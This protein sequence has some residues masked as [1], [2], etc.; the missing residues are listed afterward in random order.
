M[1]TL[2]VKDRVHD[3]KPILALRPAEGGWGHETTRSAN[4]PDRQFR[5]DSSVRI[6]YDKDDRWLET[7]MALPQPANFEPD[8]VGPEPDLGAARLAVLDIQR[9]CVHDGPGIRTTVFFRGC[10]LRCKWCHNPEAQAFVRP[11]STGC[12]RTVREIL[13]VVARDRAY[14]DR[15]AGGVTLS[16]GEPLAQDLAGLQAFL[17]AAKNEGLNVAVETAGE[18]PWRVFEAVRSRVDL[19]LFDLKVV[20]DP[21]LHRQLAGTDGRRIQDNLR[22]LV[23]TGANVKVRMCVVPGHNDS[24]ANLEATA[25]LLKSVGHKAIELMRYYDL[26]E[27]KERALHLSRTTLHIGTEQSQEALKAAAEAFASLGIETYSTATDDTRRPAIF[28][29]RVQDLHRDIRAAGYQVCIE[30]AGLKTDWC[31]AHGFSDP[32]PVRRAALLRHVL[33]HKRIEVYP[34]ELLVGNFTAKRVGGNIWV[35]YF[36]A[37]MVLTLW[38]IDRQKPVKFGCSM[39]DKVRFYTR[40]A[41]YWMTRGVFAR[42]FPAVK[43]T[44]AY[45]LRTL[46]KRPGFNNNMAGIAHFIVNCERLLRLGTT[47][48]AAEARARQAERPDDAFYDGVLL[49]LTALEEFADRYA[50]HLRD[51]ARAEADPDRRAELARM[52]DVC[53]RVPR[54]P[55]ATFHEALQ[56][57]LFLQIALCTESF[58]NAI[59][60]GR[61]DQVL[62]P[63]FAADVEAG[64]IDYDAAKELV[65]CFILKMDEV[66]FLNDGDTLFQLGK[67]FESLSPVE[68]VTVGGVDGQGR[69]ATNDVTYMI[70]DACELRPIGVNMSARIHRNSPPEYV[71]R[72]ARVYLNGSPMP[73]LNNDEV[74][75]DALRR[76]YGNPIEQIRNYS[77]VGCVEPVASDDHFANTDAANINVVLPFLQA[78]DGDTR[79]LW[80]VGDLGTLDRRLLGAVR[81][82]LGP[83]FR[84]IEDSLPGG[85]RDLPDTIDALMERFQGRLD[86]LVRDVLADQQLTESALS[87]SLTTPLASSLYRGCM[88]SGKDVYEGGT[89]INSSGIQ[90]VG[91]TDVADSLAALD[92]VV[93]RQR[94]FPLS[95]VLDAMAADFAGERFSGIREALLAVPKFGDD[96]STGAHV[97]MHRVLDCYV[98]SLRATPHAARGGKYVAGYY[99]LNVNRVYGLKTPATPSGRK[100]GEPLANSLCPHFGMRMKDLTSSLNAVAGI[101]F[102]RYAPNGATLT[103]TIDSGLFPGERGVAN[104]AGLIRGFFDRGGMQFQPNLV[105]REVLLDAYRNPGKHKDLVVRIAGYCAYFD[106][107]SDE[108]KR[109]IIA[110]SYYG[111]G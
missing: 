56:A 51:L 66:I 55:A 98:R 75:I 37:M 90:A 88:A 57:I 47:G 11:S 89:S 103:P 65:A 86:E 42:A 32:L 14:Y 16:G 19:F 40:I 80:S 50:A 13:D 35:E 6:V 30:S 71:E 73:A 38:N 64:R 59:S 41:P 60:L 78:L 101:D 4:C 105:S 83:T 79:R 74:Y 25:A 34:G 49:A 67:L 84:R 9:T 104:L 111:E 22:R 77:I 21:D 110:R 91:V 7:A 69:D 107:L 106:D 68:T 45:A 95:E 82:R 63:Y 58:E 10:P 44:V 108:L 102:A 94:R 61:L 53:A 8:A 12:G 39:A 2:V 5:I 33:G 100:A 29:R 31:K 17:G 3:H 26:H 24:R 52:A 43:D 109:E 15:T 92:E 93:F 87:A 1:T 28:T 46:E 96:A 72:I 70:L 97:W 23:A 18:V 54:N 48:L 20:G 36:G 99:G 76:E 62:Q 27:G 81:S 85:R